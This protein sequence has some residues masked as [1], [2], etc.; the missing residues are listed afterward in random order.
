MLESF[1]ASQ[2]RPPSCLNLTRV[3]NQSK[4]WFGYNLRFLSQKKIGKSFKHHVAWAWPWLKLNS[5]IKSG[6]LEAPP[7]FEKEFSFHLCVIMTSHLALDCFAICLSLMMESDSGDGHLLFHK[8]N[9]NKCVS[10]PDICPLMYS[11]N[12]LKHK[13]ICIRVGK[14]LD[15]LVL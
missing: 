13:V 14:I 9:V 3:S 4:N 15:P 7:I 2:N 10:N 12:L 1:Q 11:W 8:K 6:G 5:G